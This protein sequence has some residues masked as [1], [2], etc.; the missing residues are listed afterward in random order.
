MVTL[1]LK[2]MDLRSVAD[3]MVNLIGRRECGSP[4]KERTN[5]I[6]AGA[7]AISVQPARKKVLHVQCFV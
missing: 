6:E 1:G 3:D 4:M 2:V 7:G 5:K